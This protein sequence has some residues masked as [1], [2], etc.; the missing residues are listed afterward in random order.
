METKELAR[1]DRAFHLEARWIWASATTVA[2]IAAILM[3]VFINLAFGTYILGGL[4]TFII[5]MMIAWTAILIRSKKWH[6][7]KYLLGQDALL[8]TRP[9]GLMGITQDV[10]LYESIL[11]ISFRQDYF[12]KK[13]GYGDIDIAIPKLN[14]TLV[15][16]NVIEPSLQVPY[17]KAH[18]KHKADRPR[19][20]VT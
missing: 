18:M 8:I 16:A 5:V 9:N 13:Y 4:M 15:L 7:T 17:F 11:S 3:R 6:D 20:L 12:G 2:L 14:S 19:A 1:S 10:Y